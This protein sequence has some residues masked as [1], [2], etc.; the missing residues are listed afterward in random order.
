MT[1]AEQKLNILIAEDDEDDIV[2]IRGLVREGLQDLVG[3]LDF[4]DN[5]RDAV[6]KIEGAHYHLC[7]FDYRLGELTGL[8]LMRLLREKNISIPV[9]LMTGHGDQ[10][11]AVEAM[12]SGAIDYLLKSHL[13]VESLS[14]SI[15]HAKKLHEEEEC[16][17]RAEETLRRQDRLL[18][19]VAEASNRLLTVHDHGVAVNEA[20]AILGESVDVGRV[21]I[22]EHHVSP[23]HGGKAASLRFSWR[24][25]SGPVQ[26]QNFQDIGYEDL[27]KEEWYILLSSGK[28]ASQA[29]QDLAPSEGRRFKSQDIRSLLMVPIVID[30]IYWGFVG[31]GDC[32]TERQWSMNEESILK[33]A[34]ASLGGKLKSE[35]DAR[36]FRSIVEGTSS[37]MGDEFFRSLVFNLA[38]ALGVRC[39]YVSEFLDFAG[40]ECRVIAGWNGGNFAPAFHYFPEDTPCEEVIAGMVSFYSDSVQDAFPKDDFLARMN[41]RS[42]A[43]VP[44]F[45]S[46]LKTIGLLSVMDDKPMIEKQRALSILRIFASRAGAEL[47]RKRAEE[48]IKNMAYYD[49]LTGLPNRILLNDR[50]SL[51]LAHAHRNKKMLA[52]MYLDFDRFK[53]INDTL[54]HAIGDLLLQE[55]ARR[56]R[57]CLREGD[58]VARLGGDEFIILQ[59]EINSE[60]DATK[61]GL[62]LL[63]MVRVPMVLEGNELNITLS[64]GAAIYPIHGE[65]A[66]ALLKNA[67]AALYL[68][69]SRGRDTFQFFS[70]AASG[71]MANSP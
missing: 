11:V 49:A 64:V 46:S 44:F 13:N 58:T 25:D 26:I 40:N 41:I 42:Y 35:R 60:G 34:A 10:E 48:I 24:R 66:K 5:F 33:A 56:L 54:G 43:G 45:D 4:V 55:V 51:A 63:D 59:P 22:F 29:M 37:R 9:I 14:Q 36:A 19:G 18:Q 32:R 50:L 47:E 39:A 69:K 62:K 30:E 65:S 12:K 28:P 8:E 16:R 23:E 15:R 21:Y 27:G 7:L 17:K 70:Q 3:R 31:F 2:L 20:L 71:N 6:S 68:A 61:L 1:T 53:V 67:D 38:S 57:A 52:V